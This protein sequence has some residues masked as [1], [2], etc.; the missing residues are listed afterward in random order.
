SF[1]EA[2]ADAAKGRHA[3]HIPQLATQGKAVTSLAATTVSAG[4]NDT[5]K[6]KI[7]G[8]ETTITLKPGTYTAVS[9]AAELQSKINGAGELKEA[10][11][12]VAVKN[13]NEIGRAHV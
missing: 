13:D 1:V 10:E 3:L 11:V 6:L 2:K 5:L 4:V 9:F 12:R 8:V 7:D